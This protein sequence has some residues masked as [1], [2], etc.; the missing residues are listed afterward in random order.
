[1]HLYLPYPIYMLDDIWEFSGT[2]LLD[3]ILQTKE[4]KVKH[5]N[6]H[7]KRNSQ[8]LISDY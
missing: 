5:L 6:I 2:A 3:F 1:M 7:E 4:P 8:I